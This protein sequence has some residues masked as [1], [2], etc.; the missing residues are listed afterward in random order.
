[1]TN[2]VAVEIVTPSHLYYSGNVPMVVVPGSMGEMG[3]LPGHA[4]LIST[5]QMG[6]VALYN[7]QEKVEKRYFIGSGVVEVTQERCT[8]LT[9]RVEELDRLSKTDALTKLATT[10]EALTRAAT[11]SEKQMLENRAKFEE[12]LVQQLN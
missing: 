3:I 7:E 1:M 6:I 2:N 10:Q 5:L 9:E 11:D 8:V 4:P 12:A